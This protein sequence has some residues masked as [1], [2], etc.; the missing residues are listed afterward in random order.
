MQV[1]FWERLR[2]PIPYAAMEVQAQR[3]K[4]RVLM[5]KVLAVVREYNA[6]ILAVAN[7]RKLFTDRLRAIDRRVM[8]G[9]HKLA[10]NMDKAGLNAYQK[11][12]RKQCRE[13][14]TSVAT[15]KSG[16]ATARTLTAQV[17]DMPLLD[18]AR[19]HV[20]E[21]SEFAEKQRAQHAAA[22]KSLEGIAASLVRTKDEMYAIFASDGAEVQQQW[23]LFT[24]RLDSDMFNAM[25]VAV[26]KSLAELNKAINGDRR[27]E[28]APLFYTALELERTLGTGETVELKPT[29]QDLANVIRSVSRELLQVRHGSTFHD[30]Q[31]QN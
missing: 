29:L 7:D 30:A 16:V 13:G 6:I 28:V 17:A 20:L 21:Y 31:L 8:T 2:M 25:R 14:T 1:Q 26:K 10:W 3:E 4:Y 9:I 15:F 18:M 19:K 22:G 23:L 12:A 27:T 5:D 11:E 24:E